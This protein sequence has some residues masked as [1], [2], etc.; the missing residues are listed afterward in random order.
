M[1]VPG[2]TAT[3]SLPYAGVA[4]VL[5][6]AQGTRA[7]CVAACMDACQSAGG[8]ARECVGPCRAECADLGGGG[9]GGGGGGT[10]QPLPTCS[11]G[12]MCY[13]P[14]SGITCGC[15]PGQTCASRCTTRRDCRV[16]PELCLIVPFPLCLVP[17]C[18]VTRLCSV[19][20]YCQ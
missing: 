14:A 2:F 15:Q 16:R 11:S 5:T 8:L 3:L 20:M 4:P 19:E 6:L 18:E 17:Q 9:S 1:A 7:E 10:P 12:D 13:S